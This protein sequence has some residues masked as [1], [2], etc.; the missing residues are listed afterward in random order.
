MFL[1]PL[2]ESRPLINTL[3]LKKKSNLAAKRLSDHQMSSQVTSNREKKLEQMTLEKNILELMLLRLEDH[4]SERARAILSTSK[5][6]V[7]SRHV[8]EPNMVLLPQ[9]SSSMPRT[10]QL[11][12]APSTPVDEVLEVSSLTRSA[13]TREAIE[14][15]SERAC[16]I[17]LSHQRPV[18][19]RHVSETN[20]VPLAQVSASSSPRCPTEW[21]PANNMNSVSSDNSV[22]E[23]TSNYPHQDDGHYFVQSIIGIK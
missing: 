4:R 2:P 11:P 21:S 9:A 18:L 3:K 20:M 1:T 14:R 19:P 12:S 5:H 8:S 7:L 22:D 17:L 16:A 10:S 6:P 15:H 13:R 23:E